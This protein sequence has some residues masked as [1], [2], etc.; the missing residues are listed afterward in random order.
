MVGASLA[1]ALARLE[2]DIVL[3]EN[4]APQ[5]EWDK[6]SFDLR[7]SAITP[8]SENLFRA[9]EV[10]SSMSTDG[11]Y[12]YQNMHVWDAAGNG[13]IDFDAAELGTSHLGHIIENRVIQ[14]ALW[15]RCQQLSNVDVQCPV[16]VTSLSE[17]QDHIDVSLEEGA[18]VRTR[19]LIAA[20]GGNSFMRQ[21]AGLQ[22]RG[23]SYEQKGV[24][25]TISTSASHQ[26]TAWQVFLP[27]GPVAFL[28]LS[29]NTCSIVWSTTTAHAD[30]LL[31]LSDEDFL[32]ALHNAFGDQLGD[33]L[34]L[35]GPRAAFPL[36]L[37]HA[38][39]YVKPR[40]ALVGDAA[41][42]VHPLAG[43]GV[44]L[45]LADAATLS[46]VLADALQ[47]GEDIGAKKVL[48]RYER[49]R[50]GDNLAMLAAMD[51]FKRVFGSRNSMLT[52]LRNTGLRTAD[53]LAPLKHLLMQHA[54]GL[55]GEVPTLSRP[56]T[57][58]II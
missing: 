18:T 50:K 45:G 28:P 21:L 38:P 11:I 53:Q 27:T 19:L 9:L 29:D 4:R 57:R 13:E 33:M 43:Q 25:A 49:A 40:F 20:D 16:T 23:W 17:H 55:A 44:N 52:W 22:T 41:H 36:R 37:A 7:V 56:K 30:E 3:L 14:K 15:Q 48:R 35:R 10:W 5:L 47:Q 39:D 8:A 51:G 42:S 31:T 54:M 46:D 32:Q 58:K 1:C 6:D 2:L 24:V 26:Q 12:P 34:A